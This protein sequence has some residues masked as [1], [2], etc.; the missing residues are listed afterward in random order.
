M[1]VIKAL[2]AIG[3]LTASFNSQAKVGLNFD[4][5]ISPQL[6]NMEETGYWLFDMPVFE[7]ENGTNQIV[8]RLSK[9]INTASGSND[10]FNSDA[11]VITFDAED[12]TLLLK[13]AVKVTR[14][15]H[16]D[17]FNENPQVRL[18]DANGN[19][20][21]FKIDTLPPILGIGRDY[22]KE[23][24]RYNKNNGLIT[25]V[26][27]SEKNNAPFETAKSVESNAAQMIVY[28]SEKATPA[29]F[30]QFTR[31]AFE[32]RESNKKISVEGSQALE[33]MAYWYGE[34][35]ISDRKSILA[36]LVSK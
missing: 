10:K 13:P 16:A 6:I 28:W 36:W 21:D 14:Q 26:A 8:F 17:Q 20:I 7:V 33:M 35:S 25:E 3:V 19:N 2:L 30:K 29:E 24:V 31:L 34:A 18:V 23:L 27:Q 32:N 12:T 1:K 22:K 4:D 11:F 15:V 5:E 9:L